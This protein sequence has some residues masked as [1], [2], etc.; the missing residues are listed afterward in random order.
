MDERYHVHVT[1]FGRKEHEAIV[2]AEIERVRPH[3]KCMISFHGYLDDAEFLNLMR[4]CS[5]GLCTQD[6]TS[7]LNLTSFPSK[8]LNYMANGL[9]VISGRNRAIEESAVGDLITYYDVQS[10]ESIAQSIMAVQNQN[11]ESGIDRLRFLDS[12]FEKELRFIL[13]NNREA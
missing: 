7:Q 8:I 10:S 13:S 3:T 12:E 9:T 2:C 6:P 5:I 11:C 4:R 1:G